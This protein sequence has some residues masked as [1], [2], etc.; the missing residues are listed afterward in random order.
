MSCV[1]VL[2]KMRDIADELRHVVLNGCD[3]ETFGNKLPFT[4]ITNFGNLNP[5]INQPLLD[6]VIIGL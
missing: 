4:L 6:N 5:Q 2:C 3:P 1:D